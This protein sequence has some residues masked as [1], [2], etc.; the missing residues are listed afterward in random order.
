M[1]WRDVLRRNASGPLRKGVI[2]PLGDPHPA[3]VG[4][5]PIGAVYTGEYR[6]PRGGEWYLS[7]AYIEAY[8]APAGGLSAKYR[9]ADVVRFSVREVVEDVE[10]IGGDA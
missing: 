9:I 5:A 4:G 8:K 10:P 2:Y 6:A 7:G 3:A 1:S